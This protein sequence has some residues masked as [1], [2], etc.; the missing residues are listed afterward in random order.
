[1][2]TGEEGGSFS[3]ANFFNVCHLPP[4]AHNRTTRLSICGN[5]D[6][7]PIKG[8]AAMQRCGVAPHTGAEVGQIRNDIAGL[9]CFADG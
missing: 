3:C 8:F 7:N 2:R 5:E 4:E 1:M 6:F 9:S